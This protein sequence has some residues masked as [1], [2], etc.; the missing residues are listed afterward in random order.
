LQTPIPSD[1]SKDLS[2]NAEATVLAAKLR[3]EFRRQQE[4]IEMAGVPV[5][6]V[7]PGLPWVPKARKR[8]VEAFLNLVRQKFIG[9]ALPG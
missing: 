1:P 4:A 6:K 2:L 9:F 3:K 5:L 7:V 8:D